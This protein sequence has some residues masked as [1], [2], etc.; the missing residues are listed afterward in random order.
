MVM[1]RDRPIEGAKGGRG[2]PGPKRKK[3]RKKIGPPN[4]KKKKR[5]FFN[6]YIFKKKN[7]EL[8]LTLPKT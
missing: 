7:L 6:N 5:I 8:C 1:V 3:E 4:P 2:P